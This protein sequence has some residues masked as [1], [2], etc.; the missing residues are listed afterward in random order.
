MN[1]F[2]MQ[3]IL[4]QAQD[5]KV[6]VNQKIKTISKKKSNFSLGYYKKPVMLS[7]VKTPPCEFN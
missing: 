4:R 7:F 1:A 5:D 3:V 2:I 6:C